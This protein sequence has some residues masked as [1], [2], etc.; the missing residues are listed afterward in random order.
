MVVKREGSTCIC[1]KQQSILFDYEKFAIIAASRWSS[2]NGR[3]ELCDVR[4][5]ACLKASAERQGNPSEVLSWCADVET[6]FYPD[7][8]EACEHYTRGLNC[9]RKEFEIT[10]VAEKMRSAKE[11][12]CRMEGAKD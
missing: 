11:Q 2:C 9:D 4:P 3:N 12:E 10:S 7:A 5:D 1:S 8:E 6:G